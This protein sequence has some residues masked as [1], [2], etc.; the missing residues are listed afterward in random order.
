MSRR[1]SLTKG[2]N[3]LYF[4]RTYNLVTD[5]KLREMIESRLSLSINDIIVKS[6]KQLV[7]HSDR[8]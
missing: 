5:G 4:R 7:D 3:T 1:I 2:N 8:H 6:E